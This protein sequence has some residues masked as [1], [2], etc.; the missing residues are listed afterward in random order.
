M[1]KFVVA[2]RTWILWINALL[3]LM[4]V[5]PNEAFPT[6]CT[7]TRRRGQ[8]GTS[9]SRMLQANELVDTTTSYEVCVAADSHLFLVLKPV[10]S[11][12]PTLVFNSCNTAEDDASSGQMFLLNEGSERGERV[13][14]L[15][16]GSSEYC[17]SF[18][19]AIEGGT[20]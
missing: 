3:S 16:D 9:S 2:Q 13:A 4:M 20:V 6:I 7:N 8:E 17:D 10:D 18:G 15:V 19:S 14:M 5:N 12:R 11:S 1:I